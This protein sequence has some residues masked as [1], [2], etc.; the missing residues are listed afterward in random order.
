MADVLQKTIGA[1]DFNQGSTVVSIQT[2]GRTVN[3]ILDPEN[4]VTTEILAQSGVLD[5]RFDDINYYTG[6]G[7][8]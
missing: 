8:P 6:G 3:Q 1:N 2:T 4:N 7:T 5:S